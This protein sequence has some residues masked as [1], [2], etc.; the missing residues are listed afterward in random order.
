MLITVG[1]RSKEK[2]Q[3]ETTT[4][5]YLLTHADDASRPGI[6]SGNAGPTKL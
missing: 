5:A 4:E 3:N 6:L 2:T 1:C